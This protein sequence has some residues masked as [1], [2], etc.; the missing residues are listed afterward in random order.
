MNKDSVMKDLFLQAKVC[1]VGVLRL[2]ITFSD[3]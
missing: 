3:V 1:L 2:N